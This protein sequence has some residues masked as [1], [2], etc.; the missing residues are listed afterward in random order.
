MMLEP[1][2][3][4]L[5]EKIDS[6]YMLVSLASKRARNLQLAENDEQGEDWESRKYVSRA[7]REIA[8]DDLTYIPGDNHERQKA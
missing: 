2:I 3:D 1:S 5:L 8:A 4:E 7:L 6:K